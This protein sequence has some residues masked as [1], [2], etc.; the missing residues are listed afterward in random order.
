MAAMQGIVSNYEW[1]KTAIKNSPHRSIDEMVA[2]AAITVTDALIA[3]LD[4]T[5]PKA[6]T[7]ADGWIEH[8]PKK[9]IPKRVA[10]V[11]FKDGQECGNVGFSHRA[12]KHES[13]SSSLHITHYKLD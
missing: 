8:D 13:D 10:M 4:R 12:W 5:A 9:P 2:E 6:A 3:E 1:C 7:D 11:R